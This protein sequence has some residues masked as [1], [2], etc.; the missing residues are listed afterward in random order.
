MSPKRFSQREKLFNQSSLRNFIPSSSA[1]TGGFFTSRQN[2]QKRYYIQHLI[3]NQNS[4]Q[5]FQKGNS[6]NINSNKIPK[7]DVDQDKYSKKESQQNI[8]SFQTQNQQIPNKDQGDSGTLNNGDQKQFCNNPKQ[9]EQNIYF[10]KK[11]QDYTQELKDLIKCIQENNSIETVHNKLIREM[12][13]KQFRNV[14]AIPV[15]SYYESIQEFK[16]YF[17][18][19]LHD[20]KKCIQQL[21]N[22]NKQIKQYEDKLKVFTEESDIKF[23]ENILLNDNNS[24]NSQENM[25]K[26]SFNPNQQQS[27]LQVQSINSKDELNNGLLQDSIQKNFISNLNV[28]SRQ[29]Q[30][31]VEKLLMQL[32]KQF[33]QK[34]EEIDFLLEQ[35]SIERQDYQRQINLKQ[36]EINIVLQNHNH[37]SNI[38]REKVQSL[39]QINVNL[40]NRIEDI[41]FLG[42]KREQSLQEE[43]SQLRDVVKTF[44]KCLQLPVNQQKLQKNQFVD[45]VCCSKCGSTQIIYMQKINSQERQ[46]QSEHFSE[47]QSQKYEANQQAIM[48]QPI[49]LTQSHFEKN[50]L[51]IQPINQLDLNNTSTDDNSAKKSKQN[52]SIFLKKSQTPSNIIKK[53]F[54]VDSQFSDKKERTAFSDQKSQQEIPVQLNNFQNIEQYQSDQKFQENKQLPSSDMQKQLIT[55]NDLQ[56]EFQELKMTPFNIK[57]DTLNQYFTKIINC[58]Q[59]EIY[60]KNNGILQDQIKE[61]NKQFITQV[62]NL[63]QKLNLFSESFDQKA[64]AFKQRVEQFENLTKQPNASMNQILSQQFN[65]EIKHKIIYNENNSNL[66]KEEFNSFL[67]DKIQQQQT[68]VRQKTLIIIDNLERSF[69]DSIQIIETII[70]D[71]Q[72][73]IK[74]LKLPNQI[75]IKLQQ[76]IDRLLSIQANTQ[77]EQDHIRRYQQNKQSQN[78][79]DTFENEQQNQIMNDEQDSVKQLRKEASNKDQDQKDESKASFQQAELLGNREHI[80]FNDKILDNSSLKNE[81]VNMNILNNISFQTSQQSSH[82]LM[83]LQKEKSNYSENQS[84]FISN[85]KQSIFKQNNNKIFQAKIIKENKQIQQDVNQLVNIQFALILQ[86]CREILYKMN[87]KY[88]LYTQKSSHFDDFSEFY[89][90]LQQILDELKVCKINDQKRYSLDAKVNEAIIKENSILKNQI[91][92]QKEYYD[93]ELESAIQNLILHQ[94]FFEEKKKIYENMNQQY[95]ASI[96]LFNSEIKRRNKQALINFDQLNCS[97]VQIQN[98][99]QSIMRIEKK[100]LVSSSKEKNGAFVAV[101]SI[102]NEIQNIFSIQIK[103]LNA[104]ISIKKKILDKFNRIEAHEGLIT[105]YQLKGKVEQLCQ[106]IQRFEKQNDYL[107]IKLSEEK[108]GC[109]YL[110]KMQQQYYDSLFNYLNSNNIN[111]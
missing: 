65:Q 31:Q 21:A 86:E 63:Y 52:R 101:E 37:L 13:Q 77:S 18:N 29:L 93:K 56:K 39:E 92:E 109:K 58:L 104:F 59:Q 111:Q 105:H 70:Q 49:I 107:E 68:N 60:A 64:E 26:H 108:K 61:F 33:E 9:G 15:E 50:L 8:I 14:E 67:K 16:D 95:K 23:Q 40:Q 36:E 34:D 24:F 7:R 96:S 2:D 102:R 88:S 94:E 97:L 78:Q 71:N 87:E 25:Q 57:I 110:I 46:I 91:Q 4:I 45:D 44:E 98:N 35:Q 41:L 79:I 10:A 89:K 6:S 42:Q 11:I 66:S 99:I 38:Y 75:I 84:L 22:S 5:Y 103:K 82:Q 72:G 100:I 1:Q 17:Q 28:I 81:G 74:E 55:Y 20:I 27:S 85:K 54:F 19:Q 43:V 3:S 69:S 32:Q 47:K 12:I 30:Q 48:K 83:E 51:Q 80:K 53:Q 73:Q 90:I 62:E 106:N 76:K